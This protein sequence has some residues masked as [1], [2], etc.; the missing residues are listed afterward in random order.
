M[1][2]RLQLSD[3]NAEL[4]SALGVAKQSGALLRSGRYGAV[5]KDNVITAFNAADA[6]GGMDCTLSNALYDAL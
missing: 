1:L 3:K 5:V 6:G 4:A 2:P